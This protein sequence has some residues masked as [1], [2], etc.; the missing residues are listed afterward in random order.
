MGHRTHGVHP[1][2][3]RL[4]GFAATRGR[5]YSVARVAFGGG[6]EGMK[7]SDQSESGGEKAGAG[8]RR[9]R[10]TVAYDGTAYA[11][12]QV[13]PNGVA[14]QQRLEE[15]LAAIAGQ[16]VKIHGSGRTDRG[17]HAAG[18]VAH[19]DLQPPAPAPAALMRGLNALLPVDIRVLKVNRCATDF[20]ARHSVREKEYRYFIWNGPAV[21]PFVRLYRTP[22]RRPLDVAAM[23]A[24]A[25]M[26]VGRHDFA[27][28]TANPNRAVESTVR[29][30]S[31]LSVCRR[32]AEITIRAVSEGFLY[33]MV[34]SLAGW[35]IR[36]GEG[37]VPAEA[38]REVLA[39]HCR[40][41]HVP[42]AP[43]EGLFLWRVRY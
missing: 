36:V 33:R 1:I 4:N 40:T 9:Y 2:S 25:A 39:S 7:E 22:V 37:D 43:P 26:L 15:A 23:R 35:L 21:P 29:H 31:R 24:A 16:T 12:W 41:A 14:V 5:W 27:A 28:F 32:G 18:Q 11:G 10:M 34:R 42:T 6:V 38:T 8:R 3:H 17:V 20:H 19:F 13:Q 30:L